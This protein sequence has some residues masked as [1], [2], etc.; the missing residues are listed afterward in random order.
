VVVNEAVSLALRAGARL[1]E[2]DVADQGRVRALLLVA[3]RRRG[4]RGE[5]LRLP[6]F[7]ALLGPEGGVGWLS[8]LDLSGDREVAYIEP[9]QD[10]RSF[11]LPAAPVLVLDAEE[12]GR[13]AQ[14]LGLRF[15]APDR[16]R[17]EATLRARM[18][19]AH[20]TAA[21]WAVR[22]ARRLRHPR[23]GHE[24][25]DRALSADERALLNALRSSDPERE[26][27]MTDGA[28]PVRAVGKKRWALPRRHPDVITCARAV[29]GDA[30]WAYPAVFALYGDRGRAVPAARA[31]WRRRRPS[32][33]VA[34]T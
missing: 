10:P 6:M 25:S 4:R 29:A 16:R 13:L 3:A 9:G 11:L 28:G 12:R 5:V 18:R 31:A 33:A 1:C 21:A 24:L 17:V 27:V 32:D 26:V 34:G 30:A 15:R 7:R 22:L 14:L 19:R 20:A 2:L 23:L 8:L